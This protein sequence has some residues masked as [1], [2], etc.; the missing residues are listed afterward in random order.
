MYDGK[1]GTIPVIN[2]FDCLHSKCSEFLYYP[3]EVMEA[4][5]IRKH[6]FEEI[7]RSE[8]GIHLKH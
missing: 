8:S 7:L 5:A 4:F 1:K 3:V 2:D 6:K